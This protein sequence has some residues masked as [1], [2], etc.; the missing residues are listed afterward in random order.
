MFLIDFTLLEDK[1]RVLER[2]P[3][4]FE[5]S[6]FL[7]EDFDGLAKPSD[8]SFTHAAFW[9]RMFD[10]PLACM[11]KEIG[12]KIGESVGLVEAVDVGANGMG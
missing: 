3:W 8:L 5:G 10:L 7:I 4:V 6:L 12:R 11:G 1:E 9:V 2:R